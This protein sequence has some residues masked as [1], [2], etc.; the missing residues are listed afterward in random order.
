ME[1]CTYL[2]VRDVGWY[3]DVHDAKLLADCPIDVI[4]HTV[5]LIESARLVVSGIYLNLPP[6]HCAGLT[7][8]Q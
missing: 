3:V 6:T 7:M 2:F 4:G 1:S 5:N 8:Y